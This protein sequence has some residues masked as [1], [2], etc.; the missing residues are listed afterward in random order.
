MNKFLRGVIGFS[1]KNKYL[2]LFA[3]VVLIISGVIIF[4]QMPIEAFPDVTNTEIDIITQWPGQSA[5]EVEKLVTIPIEIALNPVQYKISLRST[6]IFG[7]SYVKV[8]FDDNIKDPEARQQVMFLLNNATLPNGITPAVQ[9]P[10]G[11]TGEIYRYTL[12]S[13][14]R[15]VRELKTIQDWVIDRRLRAIPGIGDINSFGGKTKTY[16]ITV[17]PGKV[18]TLGLTPLDVFAAI[19]KTNINVGGDMIIQNNQAFAV[20]GIGLIND[21]NQIRNIVISNNNGVPVLVNSVATVSISNVPRL[22]WVGRSDALIDK[23]GKRTVKD[24]EDVVEAIIVMRKGEN[25]TQVVNALKREVNKLNNDVLPADTKIVP[26]YDRSDLIGYATHTVLHNLVEGILLV[27]LL[28]SLFMFNWRTTLIVSIIIPMALL[29]A[30]ICLHLMGMSANLL[31]LGAVDF[32]IIIDGAVVMVEGMFVFLDHK[33]LQVGMDRFNKLAK[34][35]MI[36]NNGAQLGKAIF[37]A[38]LII[39]TGLLPVFAFQ[40]V[41]GKMFSPLAY[42]LG[43]ALLGALITTLTLVPVLISMLLNKNVHEK[44]NP[45]VHNLTGFM[46]FGFKKAFK[47][48]TLVVTISF[49]VMGIGLYSF[50]FLGSEFLPELNEGSIWLRVQLPYSVSLDKS[51]ET[52][53]QVRQIL[54]TFPQVQYAVSQTGRPDDGTD[55]AGFYNN[56]FDVLMYPEDDWKP[57]ITKEALIDQ[58]NAKLSNIPGVDLNFSQ[59]IMDNVEEAVSGVK[60]SIVVKVYG[61]SLDYMEGK[62]DEVYN[63]LKGVRGIEDLGVMRSIGLPELD[64]NLDQQKMAQYGVATADANSVISMAIGGQ[65]A[66]TLYE[67]V[68]TF[69]IRVRFP[70]AFRRT[71]EDIGNLL[72]PTQNGSKVPI[73][74]IANISQ[75]TGPCLIF[76]DENE[77]FATL[78]FSVRG[79]DMG[80]TI[81][82]AQEKVD[83][84]VKV[85]RGYHLAWQGDFENQQRAEKRL[86]QVVPVS[87]ALIFLLLFVMFG[88]FKD[89][90]LVFLNVPFAIVGGIAALLLTG[91]N[92][93]ISAGIGF[94]ALFGICIQDGVLLITVFKHNLDTIRGERLTLYTSIVLGVNSRI[95]PVMM[96]AL[97]AAIGLCPAALSHGIGS[98]SSRPLAR[99]V[100]GGILCAM[101]FSLWVFPLIFGWAY[102]KTDKTTR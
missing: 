79:R 35:G 73:R 49:I 6:T 55:V 15:D 64:I 22:G 13:T 65:A 44:H 36:K 67:G 46:L 16:E 2:I 84:K 94:I 85:K 20:R 98:E 62:V 68:R 47:N 48:K 81:A 50:K 75:K 80:S 97:M 100:I 27:T 77:R 72:V 86:T 19:Q 54:M 43:F 18:A 59:P 83:A 4:M 51:V 53:K 37:F 28:V 88:N 29:F 99:V 12:K 3:S 40:K 78:K 14:F 76:R 32:G 10:T 87:L 25:P 63:I 24:D 11:P 91:T 102:R 60:G 7:L 57:K 5:E 1:L 66:S 82:E 31:S 41:E 92:F 17:D 74:E 38:K 90:A 30:F 42:T 95:R 93:S 96:T 70:A 8:I 56:E 9:P 26:Y 101:V 45:F 23:H 39:I 69:D 61:D 21:I 89:A 58:M 52:A 33:A 71:P 34:L